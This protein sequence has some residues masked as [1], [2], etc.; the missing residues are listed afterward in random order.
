MGQYNLNRIFK[1]RQVAVL[2]VGFGLCA[3]IGKLWGSG[4]RVVAFEGGP[5]SETSPGNAEKRLI[6]GAVPW[7]TNPVPQS[8]AG[9][10]CN[11]GRVK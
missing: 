11:E 5:D 9:A 2:A 8:R 1:P 7:M 6:K 10:V 3:W 4:E